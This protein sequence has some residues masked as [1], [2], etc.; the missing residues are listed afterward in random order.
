M[1]GAIR[2]SIK[3]SKRPSPKKSKNHLTPVN[4]KGYDVKVRVLKVDKLN[5]TK[6][7]FVT[8]GVVSGLGKGITAA[9]IGKILEARGF[10]VSMQKCDP[11]LNTDAGT[12]NPAEHGEVFV[13]KDGGETDL[14]L[15]HYERFIDR[16]LTKASS[17]M[18]GEIFARVFANERKGKFLGKTVQIIPHITNEIQ[19]M[20]IE[21]SRGSDIHIVE[22][23][24]TVG[25]YESMANMEAIRQFKRRVAADNVLYVHL[26]FVPYLEASKELKT[27]PAQN[28]VRDLREVGIQADVLCVRSDHPLS[29]GAIDKLSLYCDV[30]PQAIVS[31]PTAKTVYEV[32]LRMEESQ[33]G[34]YITG[35]LNLPKRNAKLDDWYGL[36]S[37]IKKTKA[38]VTIG[39]VA[40]YL[41]HEDTYMSVFEALKSAGWYHGLNADIKWIN[42]EKLEVST[43]ELKG[44]DGI[45]VPGGFGN[46]GTEGKIIAAKYARENKVPY[47]G[48]CLGMQI[49]VIE[50]ARN[51]IGLQDANSTELNP[52]TINPVI[53]I[54]SDQVGV[55]LGGTMRLGNYPAVLNKNS[56][57]FLAYGKTDIMERHRHR[58]EFNNDFRK[59]LQGG[60]L[61]L[62]GISPDNKLVEIVELPDHPF[63]VGSQFHPEFLSR[64]D[65]PHP[66]FRDFIGAAKLIYTAK[67]HTS[68]NR[69]GV[70]GGKA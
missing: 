36:V 45:V 49:A 47:L 64:P 44:L 65:K 9:S 37:R 59:A 17:T 62:S 2:S 69:E 1:L 39:V 8:G 67:A 23:G 31:L 11:Y 43:E 56:R 40:K 51:V 66:L 46:R 3:Q 19:R 10:V 14:D 52:D 68:L 34:D 42:A 30:D 41:S 48:L 57:A 12:L 35:A 4:H 22:I 15:G 61:V 28:S 33:I 16:E 50:F 70:T 5:K 60:G 53:D 13:T 29:K 54:M 25:D 6:Y 32:P 55:E 27:K 7:I 18:N 58:Y 24:G 21:A 38:T 26:V 63:Y 20:I